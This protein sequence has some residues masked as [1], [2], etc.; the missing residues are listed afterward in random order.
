ML[1][2]SSVRTAI[3]YF[4]QMAVRKPGINCVFWYIFLS[5]G[6]SYSSSFLKG[7]ILT[8]PTN[9][10][11]FYIGAFV[12]YWF[13]IKQEVPVRCPQDTHIILHG[14]THTQG[15]CIQTKGIQVE[16]VLTSVHPLPL[17]PREG[18]GGLESG[19]LLSS[20]LLS[21]CP[22]GEV[23]LA[24]KAGQLFVAAVPSTQPLITSF[25]P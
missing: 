12:H 7:I 20:T 18:G 9:L 22:S 10:F 4:M 15:Y 21:Y 2:P 25:L 6:D 19:Q 24:F 3:P 16:R 13:C 23:L 11:L 5:N 17:P 8:T 1:P 14:Q